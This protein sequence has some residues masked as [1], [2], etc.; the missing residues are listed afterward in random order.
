MI[1]NLTTQ[2][3][4]VACFRN[5]AVHLEPGGFAIEVII[6]DLRTWLAASRRESNDSELF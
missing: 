6:L 3:A 1:I 5:L 4:Q 2:A